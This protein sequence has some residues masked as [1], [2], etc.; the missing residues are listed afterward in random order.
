MSK[1]KLSRWWRFVKR[2]CPCG[3]ILSKNFVPMGSVLSEKICPGGEIS[4]K[5]FVSVVAFL[6]GKFSDPGV[7]G[8]CYQ[9]R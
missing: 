9:S 7:R 3:G 1:Q 4:S 2:I 5:K 6:N 8:D